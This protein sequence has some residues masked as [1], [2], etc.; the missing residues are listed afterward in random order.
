MD[1]KDLSPEEIEHVKRI[2]R[3]HQL[4]VAKDV[5]TE[6]AGAQ[7]IP[8]AA[9]EDLELQQQ[10]NTSVVMRDIAR[11]RAEVMRLNA[12]VRALEMELDGTADSFEGE[13]EPQ[14]YIP[15]R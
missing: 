9:I 3:L 13:R 2:Q 6:P 10:E 7:A 5:A 1:A 14:F 8:Q 15:V 12:R 11:L 4:E